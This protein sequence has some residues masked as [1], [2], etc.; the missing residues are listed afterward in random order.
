MKSNPALIGMSLLFLVLAV[1]SSV[2]IWGEISSAAKIAMFAFGYGA[3]TAGG[4]L[5][6]RRSK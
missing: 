6:A 1:A 4:T 5:M 3:G 2:V